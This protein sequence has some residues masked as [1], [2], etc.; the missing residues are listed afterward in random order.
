MEI[1]KGSI[2][3]QTISQESSTEE[4]QPTQKETAIQSGLS[5]IPD[6]LENAKAGSPFS[7][8]PH[9]LDHSDY[10]GGAIDLSTDEQGYAGTVD[11]ESP[12]TEIQDGSPVLTDGRTKSEDQKT[13][14]PSHGY[15][16][17]VKSGGL[18][19]GQQQFGT[20]TD[21]LQSQYQVDSGDAPPDL[22]TEPG[23]SS[24]RDVLQDLAH[25]QHFGT[26]LGA[27]ETHGVREQPKNSMIADE[28]IDRLDQF[29][30]GAGIVAGA[31]VGAGAAVASLPVVIGAAG[32][33]AAVGVGAGLYA[34]VRKIDD[35]TGIGDAVVDVNVQADY[36]HE[37][38]AEE[39][40]AADAKMKADE[41]KKADEEAAKKAA[42]E[43]KKAAE[44]AAAKA[45]EEAKKKEAEEAAKAKK[46]AGGI[47][48]QEHEG[49]ELPE[50]YK[51]L[52]QLLDVV[53]R[54][55]MEN[56]PKS[57]MGG[58]VV[59]PG[60]EGSAGSSVANASLLASR[61]QQAGELN[62]VGQSDHKEETGAAGAGGSAAE[63]GGIG[64]SINYGEDSNKTGWSGP[65]RTDEESDA[66]TTHESGD[67]SYLLKKTDEKDDNAK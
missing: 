67:L 2:T 32:V 42:D 62:M 57:H 35:A 49:G 4:K 5:A 25:D 20:S 29:I 41:K 66:Q 19:S 17:S 47:P 60:E 30:E 52:S 43:A 37:H 31:V 39:F 40:Q 9:Q 26:G 21:F 12:D 8:A 11:P 65:T 6:T 50:G 56:E 38:S 36:M 58:E 24:T 16:D 10:Q 55:A 54:T 14:Y 7:E 3:P 53:T 28:K 18:K 44:E 61:L 51:E 27:D 63:S 64:G 48:D 34:G 15:L 13:N 59:N 45:A 22:S 46:K 33:A 23:N 1:R